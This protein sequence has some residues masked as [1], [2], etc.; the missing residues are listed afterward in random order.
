VK[1]SVLKSATKYG[2]IGGVKTLQVG[3]GGR[4]AKYALNMRKKPTT[5]TLATAMQAIR[6]CV[7]SAG[8]NY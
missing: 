3:G 6:T 2:K 1:Y 8:R 4:K 5:E 7:I